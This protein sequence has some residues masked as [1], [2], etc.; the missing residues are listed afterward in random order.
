M[1]LLANSP[2]MNKGKA[3]PNND[4]VKVAA[5]IALAE[6]SPYASDRYDSHELKVNCIPKAKMVIPIQG[7]IQ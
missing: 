6:F 2:A 5:A 4:L 7:T 3:A 1:N